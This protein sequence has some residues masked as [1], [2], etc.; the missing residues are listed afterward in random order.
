MA[1]NKEHLPTASTF[2]R[3]GLLVYT[4]LIIYASL[5]P[6]SGWRD[7]GIAPQAFLLAPLPHYWTFF[8]ALTNIIGY[9]PF[10]LLVAFTGYPLLRGIGAVML[11]IVAGALLSGT[12]E[13][14]QTYLPTRVPSNL[15]FLTNL[16]GTLIG[17]IIGMLLTPIFLEQSRFLSLRRHWFWHDAGR[18]LI[19]AG[20]W[21]LAQIY[22]QGYLFGHGQMSPI[23]SDWLSDWLAMSIDLSALL[24]NGIDLTIEQYWLSETLITACGMTGAILLLLVTVKQTAPRASLALTLLLLAIAI[25]SLASALL[26][27]PAN[28]FSWL[29]PGAQGGLLFASVMLFGLGF[30]PAGAQRRIAILMLVI[31]LLV[32]NAV[33]T[34]PYFQ[35]TLQN[36]AQGKFLHF[37]GAAQFL[38]LLWPFFALWFL[39]HPAHRLKAG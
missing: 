13:A 15:D 25:K 3:V 23:L 24:R 12:M 26:F 2:A 6:F 32:V 36:W 7:N 10:G 27:T 33:P 21:P 11:A 14:I 5:F 29:T 22:P 16:S 20:L 18:G 38:T 9:V 35:A 8:D 17:G 28:A 30:A 19:V 31:G 4:L 39:L 34:N 37:N 1:G